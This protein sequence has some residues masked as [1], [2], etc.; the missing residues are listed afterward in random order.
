MLFLLFFF[1]GSVLP[2]PRILLPC[3]EKEGACALSFLKLHTASYS[4]GS[5][6]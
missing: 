3:R 5:H 6:I 2:D 4:R 1:I